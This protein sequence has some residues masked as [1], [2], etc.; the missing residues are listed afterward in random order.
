MVSTKG[1]VGFVRYPS[2]LAVYDSSRNLPYFIKGL[3]K[4]LTYVRQGVATYWGEGGV[5]QG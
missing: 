5:V 4:S 3:A 1:Y 2:S